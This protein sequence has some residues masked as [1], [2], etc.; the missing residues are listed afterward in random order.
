PDDRTIVGTIISLAKSFHMTTVAEG[1]ETDEQ[2][3][4]L[5][6][7]KCDFAQG[8]LFCKPMPMNDLC[9]WLRRLRSTRKESRSA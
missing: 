8:Y 4:I 9:D 3:Q 6:A 7:M 1:V 5:R 2:L